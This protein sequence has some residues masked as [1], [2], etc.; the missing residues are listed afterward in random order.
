MDRCPAGISENPYL[1]GS[2]LAPPDSTATE[3]HSNDTKT[4]KQ[5]TFNIFNTSAVRI[6]ESNRIVTSVFDSIRNDHHYSKFLNTYRHQFLTY[7]TE[8]CRFFTLATTPSNQQNQQTWSRLCCQCR[9]KTKRSLIWSHFTQIG[10]DNT[11]M[12]LWCHK[13]SWIYLTS[14]YYW[15]LWRP[16]ITIRFNSNSEFNS[17]RNEKNTIRTALFNTYTL[18]HHT[19]HPKIQKQQAFNIFTAY[20]TPHCCHAYIGNPVSVLEIL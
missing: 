8:W 16:T 7:L 19:G 20:I 4:Q 14:T 11:N 17:I 1:P 5:Q 18:S 13:N 3:S 10:S 6:F 12:F 2:L 15:W 9:L